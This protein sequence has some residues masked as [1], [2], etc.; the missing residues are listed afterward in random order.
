MEREK[1]KVKP[2]GETLKRLGQ[3]E[4]D[5]KKALNLLATISAT[6]NS[7]G[8]QGPRPR[9]RQATRRPL[10]YNDPEVADFVEKGLLSGV[11]IRSVMAKTIEAFGEHR[12]PTRASIGR[13][14][15]RLFSKENVA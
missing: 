6:M 13:H 3:L 14:R 11:S 1:A 8:P 2:G 9:F 5:M 10:F 4:R 15:K 12:A 7:N